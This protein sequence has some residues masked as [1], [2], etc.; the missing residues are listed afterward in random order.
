MKEI[1]KVDYRIYSRS[2]MNKRN[3]LTISTPYWIF[4]IPFHGF[5]F[6]EH[7]NRKS[8]WILHRTSRFEQFSNTPI[9]LTQPKKR[10]HPH[11]RNFQHPSNKNH[12]HQTSERSKSSLDITV[13]SDDIQLTAV[14]GAPVFPSVE[15]PHSRWG[16]RLICIAGGAG[17]GV[18]SPPKRSPHFSNEPTPV[19]GAETKTACPWLCSRYSYVLYI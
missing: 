13:R 3:S 16:P 10:Q 15:S 2:I 19:L 6:T 4:R 14:C 5:I 7:W 1:Q 8:I 17:S 12:P 11:R 18:G 9:R